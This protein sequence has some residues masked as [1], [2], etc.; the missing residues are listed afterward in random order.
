MA[1]N[2]WHKELSSIKASSLV[3]LS[4]KTYVHLL[5]RHFP[6][7]KRSDIAFNRKVTII[8]KIAVMVTKTVTTIIFL[9]IYFQRHIFADSFMKKNIVDFYKKSKECNMHIFINQFFVLSWAK[10]RVIIIFL[11]LQEMYENF[12]QKNSIYLFIQV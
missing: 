2:L 6:H 1:W 9:F 10:I 7:N 11:K 5:S 8:L 4:L 3:K 12:M